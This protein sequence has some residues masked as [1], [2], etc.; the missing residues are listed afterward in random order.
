MAT[1]TLALCVVVLAS[2]ELR[3]DI[4]EAFADTNQLV[5]RYVD[6]IMNIDEMRLQRAGKKR[7]EHLLAQFTEFVCVH[8]APV[9]A[10]DASDS[11]P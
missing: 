11:M 8:M 3:V 9:C 4:V 2:G 5:R 1:A 7:N 6:D 10:R